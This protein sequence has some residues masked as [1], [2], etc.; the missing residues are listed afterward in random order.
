MRSWVGCCAGALVLAVAGQAWGAT[1]YFKAHLA[2]AGDVPA[3]AS[4]GQGDLTAQVDT[5][6]KVF[7][8][9]AIYS[10]LTGE[11][12]GARFHGPARPG[13]DAPPVV[14]VSDPSSPI[15]GEAILTGAQISDLGKGLWYFTIHTAANT[16]GEIRG[17]LSQ[18]RSA[19]T[20]EPPP[21]QTEQPDFQSD[22]FRRP[23]SL[24]LR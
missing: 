8:Y 24:S 17:Q 5:D 12:T 22:E 15:S 23:P 4:A 21:P 11:A 9:K 3:T 16:G 19:R 7:R 13:E 10:G 6:T 14:M 1:L 18:D 20:K 2:S